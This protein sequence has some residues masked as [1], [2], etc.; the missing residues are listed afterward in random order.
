MIHANLLVYVVFHGRRQLTNRFSVVAMEKGGDYVTTIPNC[1]IITT[2]V[3]TD[4]LARKTQLGLKFSRTKQKS[5]VAGARCGVRASIPGQFFG[6][7]WGTRWH[8]HR[9][10]AEYFG[11]SMPV[12]FHHCSFHKHHLSITH[13]I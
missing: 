13:A 2:Y 8:W 3:V 7:S 6:D 5:L 10:L 4:T 12:S 9:L 1:I 11:Y